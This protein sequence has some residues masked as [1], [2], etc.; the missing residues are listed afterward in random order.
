MG[1][2]ETPSP[3]SES[4]ESSGS[5]EQPSEITIEPFV[6]RSPA[7]FEAVRT[8]HDAWKGIDDGEYVDAIAM[9]SRHAGY[10]GFLGLLARDA[11][12]GQPVGMGY[13]HTDRPGQWWHERVAPCLPPER[14]GWLESCFVVVELAVRAGHRRRGIGRALLERLTGDRAEARAALSTQHD[15]LPARSLY[16]SLGWQI[17]IEPMHFTSDAPPYV[18]LGRTLHPSADAMS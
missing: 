11:D 2:A 9:I 16:S 15:N 4:S 1:R 18:V 17:L 6:P 10:P 3:P 8:Y 13:G 7:F 5:G 12:S 14:T